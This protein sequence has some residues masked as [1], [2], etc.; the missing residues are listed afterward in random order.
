MSA[1]EPEPD[2]E[3]RATSQEQRSRT[4]RAP[5]G[6]WMYDRLIPVLFVMLALVLVV[7][8]L[9]SV[10]VLTGLVHYQ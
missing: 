6:S 2:R 1:R 4:R 10:G 8:V 3:D 5:E 9:F 7:I